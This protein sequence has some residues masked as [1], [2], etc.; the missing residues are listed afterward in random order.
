MKERISSLIMCLMMAIAV[1]AQSLVM[2]SYVPTDPQVWSFIKYSGQ[3]PDLYTGTVRAEIPIYT[4]KDPDFEIPIVLSYASNGYLPNIQ[5]NFVGL[6]WTL[7]AG[8]TITR[9]VNNIKDEGFTQNPNS[10]NLKGFYHFSKLNTDPDVSDLTPAY[11][12]PFGYF[13]NNQRYESEP[14]I[15]YFSAPGHFGKFMIKEVGGNVIVFD[16]NNPYG[17]YAVD[18]DEISNSVFASKITITSGDGYRYVF[19]GISQA[20]YYINNQVIDE[21]DGSHSSETHDSKSDS[22]PLSRIIAPNG[23]QIVYNYSVDLVSITDQSCH[24]YASKTYL[25]NRMFDDAGNLSSSSYI[26]TDYYSFGRILRTVPVARLSSITVMDNDGSTVCCRIEFSYDTRLK[27]Q[28]NNAIQLNNPGRLSSIKVKDPEN[29]TIL[30]SNLSYRYTGTDNNPGNRVLLLKEVLISGTGKYTMEYYGQDNAFPKHGCSSMDHWG[31]W[32][33][34]TPSYDASILLPNVNVDPITNEET[35]LST[36]RNPNYS[37]A[38]NG[39]L[40]KLTYPTGG[41]TS[42]EYEANKYRHKIVKDGTVLSQGKP[43]LETE[44]TDIMAGGLRL[45]RAIDYINSNI[46]FIKEYAYDDNNGGSSG[47]L[48]KTPRYNYTYFLNF[49]YPAIHQ[50]YW[51]ESRTDYPAYMLDQNFIGYTQI[52][53][54][55][56]DASRDVT[57]YSGYQEIEDVTEYDSTVWNIAFTYYGNGVAGASPNYIYQFFRDAQSLSRCRGKVV[58]RNTYDGEN[59]LISKTTFQY[60]LNEA[61]SKKISCIKTDI[62]SIYVYNNYVGNYPLISETKTLYSSSGEQPVVTTTTYTYNSLGQ[63]KKRSLTTADNATYDENYIYV[64]DLS[65]IPRSVAQDTMIRRNILSPFIYKTL[66]VTRPGLTGARL[67]EGT[68]QDHSLYVVAGRQLPVVTKVSSAVVLPTYTYTSPYALTW[69]PTFTV[70]DVNYYGRPMEVKDANGIYTTL[71]W[72]YGGMYPVAKLENCRVSQA[73]AAAHA[74]LSRFSF[75]W[76]GMSDSEAATFRSIPGTLLTH[77]KYQPLIGVTEVTDPSGRKTSY[78]YNNHGHL[79]RT[80]GPDGNKI[81]EYDYSVDR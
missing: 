58:Q 8:G 59:N 51:S 19:G 22:W 70:T 27:E 35:I 26:Y 18:L 34:S 5:A 9:T 13:L 81:V 69:N 63:L 31:F 37:V 36:N 71:F 47:I 49:N 29:N 33:N 76:S 30:S 1:H 46:S 48:Y 72:G 32:N 61:K 80:T 56:P 20:D 12:A 39:M 44:Q 41:W 67:I 24:P 60:S 2:D 23:R 3:T 38:I 28:T 62:D 40:E 15:F 53:E 68:K 43:V 4:Y 17:E 78:I 11:D 66:S 25:A 50:L 52:S 21:S 16:S 10:Q 57:Y 42:Y 73:S 45:R 55:Y 54:C 74:P 79:T 64:K 14:D 7:I 77:W 65:G 6:G 75:G